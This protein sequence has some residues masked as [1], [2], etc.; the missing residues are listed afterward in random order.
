MF[1]LS[2]RF[3]ARPA[4]RKGAVKVAKAAKVLPAKGL[5]QPAASALKAPVAP[6]LEMVPPKVPTLGIT[7]PS[8]ATVKPADSGKL[9]TASPKKPAKKP[10]KHVAKVTKDALHTP[11]KAKAKPVTPK[12][13]TKPVK[14][15]LA[16][17]RR[18]KAKG[19]PKAPKSVKPEAPHHATSK[20]KRK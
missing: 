12:L 10:T 2:Y 15:R 6:L 17:K 5:G 3:M 16:S 13:G 1:R 11:T 7:P 8:H 20:P 19:A 14:L 18:L 4:L 9:K